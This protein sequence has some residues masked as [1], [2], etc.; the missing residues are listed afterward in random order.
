MGAYVLAFAFD[1]VMEEQSEVYKKRLLDLIDYHGGCLDTGF[2]ATPFILD[3]LYKLGETK[4]A[5]NIL[6]QNKQ[7]SWLYQVEQ[8]ATA[9]WEAWDADKAKKDGR[10]VSFD[11]YAFGCVDDWICRHIAGIDS[12]VPGFK[13]FLIKPDMDEHLTNCKRTYMS[14]AGE[15]SV[16]WDEKE[17]NV[18]IPC[19]TTAKVIW[20]GKTIEL[21]SGSYHL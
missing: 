2:L 9:I 5:Y 21:G 18:S 3:V 1:L 13:H 17:L 4:I 7:P 20:K 12:D 11:H 15:I 14:E 16:S 10:L 6:W 19:N 8:G